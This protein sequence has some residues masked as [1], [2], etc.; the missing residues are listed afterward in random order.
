[1][2]LSK[3]SEKYINNSF[4]LY[5]K[6]LL[7]L[8]VLPIVFYKLSGFFSG[9]GFYIINSNL[10]LILQKIIIFSLVVGLSIPT[11]IISLSIISGLNR[12][13]IANFFPFLN[14]FTIFGLIT[15]LL[16]QVLS[17]SAVVFLFLNEIA[18]LKL[19]FVII[20]ISLSLGLV[21]VFPLIIKGIFNFSKVIYIPVIG[22]V[23]NNEDHS[24]IF[25]FIKNISKSIKSKDPKNIVV[26]MSTDF[27]A[28]S[29][30]INVFNG[31]NEV[32]LKDETIHISLPFLR[33]LTIKEVEGIIGHEL[34]HF[35]GDDTLYAIK[36][37]PI[38]RRLNQQFL[39]LEKFFE[40]KE[41]TK[42]LFIKLAVY[43]IILLFNEFTRKEEKISKAQELK[44]DNF[45]A[46][47]SGGSLTFIKALSKIYIYG[48][49]W[50]ETEDDFR[51]MVKGKNFNSIKN[52][53]LKF[54][55]NAKILLDKKKLLKYLEGIQYYEQLHP[56]DTHP[57]LEQRMKNL[58]IN[59]N[60]LSN[61]EL[62]NFTPSA[63]SLI[64]KIDII[65]QNLT[66]V[67]KELEK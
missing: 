13:L 39:E 44:A 49:I 34:G 30:D 37:A 16:I 1:M 23:L 54:M 52:L 57:N 45:G 6:S 42:S 65:E 17:F 38:Y 60:E 27:Y 35:E 24:E 19:I 26:S 4:N 55:E 32:L 22:V 50:S 59:L 56:S 9:F 62:T 36:F 3:F 25:N 47:T 29:K 5:F 51:E 40:K 41:N 10:I 31:V 48:M 46:K 58:N 53:S 43:P 64:P 15:Y 7:I 61:E 18:G 33:I 21:Y 11:L 66:L 14:Y 67:L 2:R 8:S 20:G 63:A 12:K 28:I